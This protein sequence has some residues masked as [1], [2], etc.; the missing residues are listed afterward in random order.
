MFM[1]YFLISVLIKPQVRVDCGTSSSK[2][3]A[4]FGIKEQVRISHL[5]KVSLDLCTA[6]TDGT[7]HS[8]FRPK[9]TIGKM[10]YSI[11][12]GSDFCC[13]LPTIS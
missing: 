2:S 10:S 11:V 7:T 8:H 6:R 5:S 3:L 9:D 1:F 13:S 4:L 12:S